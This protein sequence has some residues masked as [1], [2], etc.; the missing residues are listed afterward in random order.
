MDFPMK[1]PLQSEAMARTTESTLGDSHHPFPFQGLH[2]TEAEAFLLGPPHWKLP[3]E[4]TT[5]PV[6][7][8]QPSDPVPSE[9]LAALRIMG[10]SLSLGEVLGSHSNPSLLPCLRGKEAPQQS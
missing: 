10:L 4:A 5:Q 1:G 6:T 7:S 9:I 2:P 3:R 8:T